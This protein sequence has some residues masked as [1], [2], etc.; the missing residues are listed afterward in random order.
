M[1]G[2]KDGENKK[3]TLRGAARAVQLASKL[4]PKSQ[5]KKEKANS[6]TAQFKVSITY[7]TYI[8]VNFK[9]MLK[10]CF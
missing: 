1:E 3:H 6:A 7:Y 8:T 2:K 4:S 10:F 9:K 5:R